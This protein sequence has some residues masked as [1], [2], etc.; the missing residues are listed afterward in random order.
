MQMSALLIAWRIFP[1]SVEDALNT[2]TRGSEAISRGSL[3]GSLQKPVISTLGLVRRYVVMSRANFPVIP[4][5]AILETDIFAAVGVRRREK[6]FAENGLYVKTP[7][8][9]DLRLTTSLQG[10]NN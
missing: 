3:A 4:A 8:A 5:I 1:V 2:V 6:S 10:R 9:M 7:L